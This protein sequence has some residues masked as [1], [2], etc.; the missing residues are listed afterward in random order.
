MSKKLEPCQ[1]PLDELIHIFE[2]CKLV[3]DHFTPEAV[4]AAYVEGLAA[5]H[6]RRAATE[7]NAPL[8]LDELREMDGEPVYLVDTER[9]QKSGWSLVGLHYTGTTCF[10][11]QD[12]T[13]Y[14][15]AIHTGRIIVY[16]RPPEGGE[17]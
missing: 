12:D 14:E 17:V 16:R 10:V 7:A 3:S 13:Y 6:A 9:P 8:T 2:A 5:L 4:T 11:M 15:T 1:I